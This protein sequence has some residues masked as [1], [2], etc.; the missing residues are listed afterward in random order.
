M[1]S[2]PCGG[3][4]DDVLDHLLDSE[5]Y[6]S[7]VSDLVEA[8]R[9]FFHRIGL[10]FEEKSASGHPA[11]IAV[12]K[13]I[14]A[15]AKDYSAAIKM[16]VQMARHGITFAADAVNLCE[17]FSQ[18]SGADV[19]MFIDE[20][21]Q[22]VH[23]AHKDAKNTSEQ[24]S[25]ITKRLP[26]QT[27]QIA[28]DLL[29]KVAD[30]THELVICSQVILADGN[31]LSTIRIDMAQNSWAAVQMDY[32]EYKTSIGTVLDLCIENKTWTS[33]FKRLFRRKSTGLLHHHYL[34]KH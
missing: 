31:S 19:C 15:A 1:G 29:N 23:L 12:R 13:D 27:A 30:N 20:M 9:E 5:N 2:I 25:A 14:R 26:L 32:M 11:V 24:F 28:A 18:H 17:H 6:A 33:T 22:I 4:P 7:V 10:L 21:R 34:H 16:S 3:T 8:V